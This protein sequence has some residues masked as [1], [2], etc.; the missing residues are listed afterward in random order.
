VLGCLIL[1][2]AALVLLMLLRRPSNERHWSPDQQ[3]LAHAIVRYPAVRVEDVRNFTYGDDG[4]YKPRYETRQYDLRELD[5]VWF[6]VERF[7]SVPG[8]A[9]TFLS[10]GFGDEFLAVSVEVRKEQGETYS[11]LKG[12][13]REYEIMYV[14]ADERDLIGL[15]T[16]IRKDQVYLYPV[17]TTRGKARKVF[18]DMMLRANSLAD[19]PEFYN[20]LT[21]TCTTNIVDHVNT[22]APSRV[23]FSFRVLL[24]AYSDKLAY[25]LGLIPNREPFEATQERHRIDPIAQS[26][27]I[28]NDF[29]RLIR[30]R[31]GSSEAGA[32]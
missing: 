30:E 5:S 26:R 31:G 18:L 19:Q 28:T 12:L 8:I 13:F 4:S 32:P 10:F 11:A 17:S 6:V 14:V 22:I 2:V 23:P 16:N 24:P 29:S 9:H 7:G 3:R 21:N 1:G 27:G 20:T 15:R 25:D